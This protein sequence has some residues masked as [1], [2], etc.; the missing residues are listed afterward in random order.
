MN[1]GQR[2]SAAG[3]LWPVELRIVMK[4]WQVFFME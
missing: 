3:R 4:R 1:R 2:K